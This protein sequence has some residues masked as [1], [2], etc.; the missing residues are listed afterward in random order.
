M[1]VVAQNAAQQRAD[2]VRLKS[3]IKSVTQ[4]RVA[5]GHSAWYRAR[6]Q[7]RVECLARPEG[8]RVPRRIGGRQW[9]CTFSASKSHF[10][11]TIQG[12]HETIQGLLGR[13]RRERSPQNATASR[14]LN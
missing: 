6:F 3:L 7:I 2:L 14:F 10:P 5:A 1:P 11:K 9:P 8:A 13:L 4:V 12:G